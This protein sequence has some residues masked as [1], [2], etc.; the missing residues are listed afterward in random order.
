[1]NGAILI[2]RIYWC[3]VSADF[4]IVHENSTSEK[5]G[6]KRCISFNNTYSLMVQGNNVSFVVSEYKA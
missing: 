3:Y 1:M 6:N 4:K 2:K 5:P